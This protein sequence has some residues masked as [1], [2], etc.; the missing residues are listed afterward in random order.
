MREEVGGTV[1]GLHVVFQ[2]LWASKLG[3]FQELPARFSGSLVHSWEPGRR[4]LPHFR[5][6]QAGN[7]QR[8]TAVGTGLTVRKYVAAAQREGI[9]R[10]GP[11]HTT[12]TPAID[13]G[14]A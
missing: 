6:W 5:R 11:A 12:T 10:D 3:D 2:G 8:Q 13:P 7:S 14:I 1:S 4:P 9:A